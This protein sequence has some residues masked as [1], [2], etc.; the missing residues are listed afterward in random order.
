MSFCL[1]GM[2]KLV[3]DRL[4][5]GVLLQ[6]FP[7]QRTTRKVFFIHFPPS[8]LCLTI[9]L[10][11]VFLYVFFYCSALSLFSTKQFPQFFEKSANFCVAISPRPITPSK[12]VSCKNPHSAPYFYPNLRIKGEI[13][14]KKVLH[15]KTKRNSRGLI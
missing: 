1:E 4:R 3:N 7:P 15:K 9:C 13:H 5:R 10:F 2:E 14:A 11:Y 12:L 8:S 6:V